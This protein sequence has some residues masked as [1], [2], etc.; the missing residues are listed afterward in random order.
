MRATFMASTRD[1]ERQFPTLTVPPQGHYSSYQVVVVL[2]REQRCRNLRRSEV[3]CVRVHRLGRLLNQ[4]RDRVETVCNK[5]N[6]L[7]EITGPVGTVP[8]H[9]VHS[10]IARKGL[11]RNDIVHRARSDRHSS[12]TRRGTVPPRGPSFPNDH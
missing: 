8:T 7:A 5:F 1:W 12:S 11:Q 3:R 9:R 2:R 6:C 10:Q 4:S